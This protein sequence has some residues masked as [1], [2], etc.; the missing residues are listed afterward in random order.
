MARASRQWF[1]A[2][3]SVGNGVPD[4]RL[5][6]IPRRRRVTSFVIPFYVH[7]CVA[8]GVTRNYMAFDVGPGAGNTRND[9]FLW[10][11][12][13]LSPYRLIRQL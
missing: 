3:A 4:R 12:V 13:A 10:G 1:A 6:F 11:C 2:S 5:L 9:V 7:S 8:L